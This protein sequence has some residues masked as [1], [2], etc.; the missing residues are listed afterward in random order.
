MKNYSLLAILMLCV[1]TTA[2][3]A[4]NT[5]TD[6]HLPRPHTASD[7]GPIATCRPGTKC[8]P[9]VGVREVASDGGPIATCRPGT[10]CDPLVQSFLTAS[11][12]NQEVFVAATCGV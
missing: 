11:D 8:D 9:V 2:A 3:C 5:P 1:V 4:A 12:R 10:K 7:G 6:R